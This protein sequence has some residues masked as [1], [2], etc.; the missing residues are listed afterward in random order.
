MHR[1]WVLIGLAAVVGMPALTAW[2]STAAERSPVWPDAW[3]SLPPAVEV[4]RRPAPVI[5]GRLDDA[6]WSGAVIERLSNDLEVRL[7]HDGGYLFLAVSSRTG[8][9]FPSACAVQGDTVRVLHASAALGS[10]S[11]R[12]SAAGWSTRDT[13]FVYGMRNTDTTAGARAERQE[14]LDRH[15]WLASTFRMGQGRV[16]ELQISLGL[17]DTEGGRVPRVAIGYFRTEGAPVTW[18]ESLVGAGEGCADIPLLRGYVS[19]HPAFQPEM[20]PELGLRP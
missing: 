1:L 16:H 11:Y 19:P 15:R 9:G 5:D 13:A 3:M 14:Y 10:V 17:F 4:P 12:R 20:Y 6:E 7:Q 18:P 2:I 8:Q